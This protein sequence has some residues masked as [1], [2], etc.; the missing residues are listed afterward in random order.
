M[1]PGLC[2]PAIIEYT[3]DIEGEFKDRVVVTVDGEVVEIP[4]LA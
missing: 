1:A 2:I 3:S 4:L